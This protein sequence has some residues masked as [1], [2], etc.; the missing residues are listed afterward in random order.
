MGHHFYFPRRAGLRLASLIASG[1]L[2]VGSVGVP[3][4]FA[5]T[6]ATGRVY[7]TPASPITIQDGQTG[8]VTVN[9]TVSGGTLGA[10]QIDVTFNSAQVSFQGCSNIADYNGNPHDPA[11]SCSS[12]GNTV[13]IIGANSNSSGLPTGPIATLDFSALVPGANSPLTVTIPNGGYTQGDGS[14][15]PIN[16]TIT[17]GSIGIP[18]VLSGFSVYSGSSTPSK[19]QSLSGPSTG[20]TVT[21]LAGSGLSNVTQVWFGNAQGT[22]LSVSAN[23][24]TVTSPA[25]SGTVPVTVYAPGEG[26]SAA[27][28]SQNLQFTYVSTIPYTGTGAYL[29]LAPNQSPVLPPGG[30]V[31]DDLYLNAPGGGN[32]G[33][34]T[35][36]VPVP[37]GFTASC[38]AVGGYNCS[39]SG[40]TVTATGASSYITGAKNDVA[41]ITFSADTPYPNTLPDT[42]NVS[43]TISS[44]SDSSGYSVAPWSTIGNSLTVVT[45]P[46]PATPNPFNVPPVTENFGTSVA[47]LDSSWVGGSAPIIVGGSTLRPGQPFTLSGSDFLPNATVQFSFSLGGTPYTFNASNVTVNTAGTQITGSIPTIP[48]TWIGHLL[49]SSGTEMARS[50]SAMCVLEYVAGDMGTTTACATSP[51][52]NQIPATVTVSQTVPGVS[53]P[54]TAV[55][56][57]NFTYDLWDVSGTDTTGPTP[58]DALC[59]LRASAGLPQTQGCPVS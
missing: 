55:L 54:Y 53:T 3:G 39:V 1:A 36:T 19:V 45:T 48:S 42:V 49:S 28:S 46:V 13:T 38:T 43:P 16:P 26:T 27:P 51:T 41:S 59:M 17:N 5:A 12:S 57:T 11:Y 40:S 58:T 9:A 37:N 14:N 52:T 50:T 7:L 15:P 4:A 8:G 24:L 10:V 20:N 31:T 29:S 6:T 32:I 2:V 21:T 47:S 35:V 34:Y 25:G 33:A 44:M 23:S 22:N 18:P 56:P 30:S